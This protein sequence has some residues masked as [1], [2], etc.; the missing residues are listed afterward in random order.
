MSL[1][2]LIPSPILS[3]KDARRW[4]HL[5]LCDAECLNIRDVWAERKLVENELAWLLI[6]RRPRIVHIESDGT[7]STIAPGW[8]SE[9]GGCLPWSGDIAPTTGADARDL[10]S[11]QRGRILAQPCPSSASSFA[12]RACAMNGMNF[13][14]S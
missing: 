8:K 5:D 4:H 2:R 10:Q 7:Q 9:R 1:A 3:E 13:T 14:A 12:S 6:H 11:D